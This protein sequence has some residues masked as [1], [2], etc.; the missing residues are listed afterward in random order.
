MFSSWKDLIQGVPQGSVLGP[1]LFNIYLNDLFFFIKD[2]DVCNFAYDTTTFICDRSLQNVLNSLEE[3][4]DL[5]ICWF[6]NNYMK[7]N[8]DKCHL[9]ISNY[10]H[11]EM[12]AKRGKDIIWEKSDVKLLGG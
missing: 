12:W 3:N 4:A 10:K 5:A 1:L 9:L 6:E 2:I 8:T 7:L 11:E